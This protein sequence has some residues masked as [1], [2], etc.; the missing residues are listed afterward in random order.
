MIYEIDSDLQNELSLAANFY[1]GWEDNG[2]YFIDNEDFAQ[3]IKAGFD[4]AFY[5]DMTYGTTIADEAIAVPQY[6]IH[7]YVDEDRNPVNIDFTSEPFQFFEKETVLDKGEVQSETYY[8]N[9]TLNPTTGV[10]TYSDPIV[11]ETYTWLRDAMGFCYR[12]E[13]L[14]EWFYEDETIGPETKTTGRYLTQV[15]KI[16]EGKTRRHRLINGLQI[17][18]LQFMILTMP[19][20]AIDQVQGQ[21]AEQWEANRQTRL[22]ITGRNFL[23]THKEAFNNFGDDSNKQIVTDITNASDAW[24]DNDIS[25]ITGVSGLTIRLWILDQLDIGSD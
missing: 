12:K 6:K 16:E 25:A 18:T 7:R 24:L 11:R 3:Y 8:A 14:I 23:A 4:V 10:V 19:M 2:K 17:P 13:T 21:T 15:E 20:E 1:I 5:L 9:A 22:I